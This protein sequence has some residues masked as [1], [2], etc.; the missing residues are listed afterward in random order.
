MTVATALVAIGVTVLLG[1][2]LADRWRV[3]APLL[4]TVLGIAASY[5]P[6]LPAVHVEPEVVMLGLLP[7][8][9]Y[10]AA[11]DTSLVDL[12]ANK[13]NIAL[14][15]V[16]LVI[17]TAASV[18]VVLWRVLDIPLPLAIAVGGVVAPPDAVAATAVA[19]RIGLPRRIVTVLEGESLFND[20]T[21]LVVVRMGMLAAG[22]AIGAGQVAAQ[23]LWAA[24]GGIAVGIVVAKA[25]ALIRRHLEDSLADTAVGFMAP[26]LAFLPAEALH[27]S[28]VLSVVVAGVLLGHQAP[29]VQTAVSRLAER[30]NWRTVQ[31]LLENAVFLLIGLQARGIV[32]EVARSGTGWWR[33]VLACAAVLVT[34]VLVRPLTILAMS[35]LQRGTGIPWR[36]RLRQVAVVSWAGMRGVVTLAAAVTLPVDAPERAVLVLVAL[37]VTAGTL[38]G[39][40]AT[41]PWLARRLDIH[42]PDPREDLLQ[43]ATVMQ[44][45]VAAGRA[46]LAR[47]VRSEDSPDVVAQL[48]AQAERRTHAVWERL[49]AGSG[50]SPSETQR[51]LRRAMLAAERAEVLR[52][53]DTGTVDHEVL[54]EVMSA[55]DLEESIVTS[56]ADRGRDHRERTLLT[57]EAVRGDCDHLRAA[58]VCTTPLTPTGCASCLTD[59]TT[60]V[61]LRICLSCG[62]VGCCDSSPG[63][64]ASAHF[65]QS[66]HPVMRSFEPGE[67]WRWCFVDEVL[68]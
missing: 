47:Q 1:T 4:L 23:F 55:L 27:C 32:D 42:G 16:G 17:L 8:L 41:L 48:H 40:G 10:A 7:P 18:G 22:T 58:P 50:E 38:V 56:L 68:G 31:Y 19:R 30:V 26:W 5:L 34:V 21:A 60:W 66:G 25:L 59:G 51:R 62:A 28:G 3:S 64:H 57:P 63:R 65:A 9:L 29:V 67:A 13:V 15:S 36:A 54:G 6:V 61:H 44:R 45:S 14:L 39:Q 46:E 33:A 12:G 52:I 11:I 35:P 24:G 2:T 20:A 53:R 37:A 49:G 43:T